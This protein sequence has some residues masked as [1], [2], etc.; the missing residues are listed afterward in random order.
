MNK[1]SFSSLL[2]LCCV[3]SGAMLFSSCK[4][5]I[6]D[7][8]AI[9]DDNNKPIQTSYNTEYI[10]SEK[11][12]ISN[13]LF[14]VQLDQYQGGETDYVEASGGFAM[15]FYDSLEREEARITAQRGK[16][17]EKEKKLIAWDD[18]KLFNVKGEKLETSELVYEQLGGTI[19]TDKELTITTVNGSII[20]GRG[21]I[22]NDSFTKYKI[23]AP[24]GDLYL[25][26]KQDSTNEQSQ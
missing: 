7:I 26:E 6:S 1:R 10:F 2:V 16:Y 9:T 8:R 19:A 3:F 18:V 14:A 22:S 12:K 4:N 25:D 20:H 13:R 5:E 17:I 11:G 21:L 15:I 24:T 23:I